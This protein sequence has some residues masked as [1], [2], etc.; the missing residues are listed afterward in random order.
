MSEYRISVIDSL[1]TFET[2]REEWSK[3]LAN[4]FANTIFLTWEWLYSWAETY[5]EPGKSLFIVAVYDEQELIG[6]APWYIY[7]Q[8]FSIFTLRKIHFLGF[9][10]SDSDYLDVI[11]MKGKE[12][13]VV[14]ALYDYLFSV[15]QRVWDCLYLQ[16]IPADSFFLLR[17][18]EKVK[19]EGKFI[20]FQPCSFC[21]A[22][23]LPTS[24]DAFLSGLSSHHRLQLRR[25]RRMI[26]K[27]DNHKFRSFKGSECVS[28]LDEFLSFHKDKKGSEDESFYSLLK[29]FV[30]RCK[31]KDW[32]QIDFLFVNEVPAAALFH[33]NYDN[34][35]SQ[36]IMVTDKTV[37]PKVSIGNVLIGYCIEESI[38]R[39]ISRYDFLK[40]TEDFKF[41]WTNGGNSSVTLFMPQKKFTPFLFTLINFIKSAAK[42]AL[43]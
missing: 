36:Y 29:S 12:K 41:S 2:L 11:I 28:S 16:D 33:F 40:G 42:V 38:K 20:D 25:H 34:A 24:A 14:Q 4:S 43:R 10:N 13:K 35:L 17:L 22:T 6:I 23:P 8:P 39:C 9:P 15:A 30:N 5:I 32:V 18:I 37:N 21:P 3:L 26:E 19:E 31:D 7:N 1:T 27:Y